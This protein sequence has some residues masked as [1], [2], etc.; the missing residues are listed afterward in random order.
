M[1]TIEDDRDAAGTELTLVIHP[2]LRD[3]AASSDERVDVVDSVAAAL[4][5][6]A[7]R[8]QVRRASVFITPDGRSAKKP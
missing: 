6:I 5:S 7:E 1:R 4:S 3:S 8:I 2:A